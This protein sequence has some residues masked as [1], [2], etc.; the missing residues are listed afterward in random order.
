M[1]LPAHCLIAAVDRP[2]Q[3]PRT[4][5]RFFEVVSTFVSIF[6]VS[7][8]PA[9]RD[10]QNTLGMFRERLLLHLGEHGGIEVMEPAMPLSGEFLAFAGLEAYLQSQ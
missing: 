8:P 10:P 4:F 2:L 1:R 9:R 6:F 3:H 5:S 7:R